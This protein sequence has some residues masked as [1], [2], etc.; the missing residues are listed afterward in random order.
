M[1]F[2]VNITLFGWIPFVIFYLYKRFP[3]Q[4]AVIYGFILAWLFLPVASFTFP[5]IPDLTKTSA[6][7]YAIFFAV[8]LYDFDRLEKLRP[9]WVDIPIIMLC[10]V[11]FFSS[12]SNGLGAYDGASQTLSR[13]VTWGMPYLI[14]R[15]FL[16]DATGLRRLSMGMFMGGLIYVPLCLFEVRMSPQLHSMVYGY[17]PHSFAQTIRYG[18]WRP[19]VFMQHGLEVGMWMMAATLIGIWLWRSGALKKLWGYPLKLLVPILFV[20][21]ILVKSTGAYGLLLIGLGVLWL[22][23]KLKTALPAFVLATMIIIHAGFSAFGTPFYATQLVSYMK[24]VGIPEERTASLEFRWDNEEILAEKA[25][26][27]IIF[28]WGGWGRNRVYE[29]NWRG[30]LV[31]VSVTD[32]LW[33]IIYGV[34]GL[35][36]LI[37]LMGTLVLPPVSLFWLKLPAKAWEKPQA[38][39]VAG[40]GVVILLYALDCLLN[41]MVNPIFILGVG[42]IA[43]LVAQPQTQHRS[44]RA[45]VP[46]QRQKQPSQS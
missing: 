7:S 45:I 14:G 32:S 11:P 1:G 40:L 31:D 28:G 24:Q 4:Q 35:F 15:I 8:V 46:K 33:I 19:N 41:A 25:Q 13:F 17:F 37:G 5:G 34:N 10:I 9:H 22:G 2:L 26:Q 36:G 20:T 43:E 3:S 38:A 44:R 30:E 6:A 39:P 18:G 23:R 16:N 42:G 27:R 29:E 12:L 21:F